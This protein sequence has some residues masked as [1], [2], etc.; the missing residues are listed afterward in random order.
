MLFSLEEE[1]SKLRNEWE[2][3]KHSAKVLCEKWKVLPEI[4][5]KR[6]RRKKRFFNELQADECIADAE[7]KFKVE[8]LYRN[9]D[10][11]STL[12][13]GRFSAINEICK[14]FQ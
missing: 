10:I 3:V 11:I 14:T 1:I 4:T 12:L 2:V 8:V 7:K 5:E 13:N 6:A 9:H